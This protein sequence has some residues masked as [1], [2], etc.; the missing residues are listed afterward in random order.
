MVEMNGHAKQA[1]RRSKPQAYRF[2]N[3]NNYRLRVRTT[4]FVR[5][6]GTVAAPINGVA[7]NLAWSARPGFVALLGIV[8]KSRTGRFRHRHEAGFPNLLCRI[9]RILFLKSTSDLSSAMAS[10]G[11]RPVAVR[12][13]MSVV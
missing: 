3:F 2:R 11:R 9:A 5:S 13:P 4:C 10:P 12:S 6:S 1:R 7:P 8:D